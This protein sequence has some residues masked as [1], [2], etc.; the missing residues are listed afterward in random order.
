MPVHSYTPAGDVGYS[1]TYWAP[2]TGTDWYSR[3]VPDAAGWDSANNDTSWVSTT[4]FGQQMI[5]TLTSDSPANVS[6]VTELDVKIRANITD[7]SAAAVLEVSLRD[8]GDVAIGTTKDLAGTSNG[9]SYGTTSNYDPAG[10]GPLY[11]DL[12]GG[13]ELTKSEADGMDILIAFAAAT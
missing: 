6:Q 7:G 1:A 11:W 10:V 13:S 12:T 5:I 2:N 3:V 4:D 8:S 9:G